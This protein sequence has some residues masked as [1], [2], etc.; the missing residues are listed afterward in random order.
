MFNENSTAREVAE[1]MNNFSTVPQARE[2]LIAHQGTEHIG[3]H[4]EGDTL[5]S[6]FKVHSWD[7][8]NAHEAMLK[9]QRADYGVNEVEVEAA[10]QLEKIADDHIIVRIDYPRMLAAMMKGVSGA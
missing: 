10:Y 2:M 4:A 8:F 1:M 3:S 6:D 9:E 7:R 5:V